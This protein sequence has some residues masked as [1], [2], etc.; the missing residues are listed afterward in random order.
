MIP[1]SLLQS[2]V[3]CFQ[4]IGLDVRQYKFQENMLQNSGNKEKHRKENGRDS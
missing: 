3:L 2:F 4:Q 1:V